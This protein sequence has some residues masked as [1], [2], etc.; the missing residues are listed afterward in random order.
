MRL[1]AGLTWYA[2]LDAIIAVPIH[3][4]YLE[5]AWRL[6]QRNNWVLVFLAPIMYV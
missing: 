3:C 4:F 6:T 5:R 2:V 1:I